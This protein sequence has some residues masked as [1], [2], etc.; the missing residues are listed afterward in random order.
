LVYRLSG[1]K[2][3]IYKILPQTQDCDSFI[4]DVRWNGGGN[5]DNADAVAQAFIKGSF[6]NSRAKIPEHNGAYKAWGRQY[7]SL[8][9]ETNTT[10]IPQCPLY[11]DSP[12]VI[13][14]NNSSGSSFVGCPLTPCLTYSA[15]RFL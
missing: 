3:N 8:K 4:I 12:L 1:K 7:R 14:V 13:L 6:Q 10:H 9:D 11:I 2:R 15:I 5:S